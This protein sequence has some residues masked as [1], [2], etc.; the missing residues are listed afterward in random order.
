[1]KK[2][3]KRPKE[4]QLLIGRQPLLEALREAVPIEKIWIKR[5]LVREN[6]QEVFALAQQQNIPVQE[7]PI[8]KLHSLTDKNHQGIIAWISAVPYQNLEDILSQVY[9]TGEIPLFLLLDGITDVRNVGAIARSAL[10]FGAQAM[11]VP[12]KGSAALNEDALKTSA[13]ALLKIPVCR[14][15]SLRQAISYLQDNGLQIVA[16]DASG[17]VLLSQ[18]DLRIP[19][20]IVLGDEG[21]GV[22]AAHLQTADVVVQIPMREDFDSLNVSVAAGVLL[23]EAAQQRTRG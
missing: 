19:T 18:A 1:M 16:A 14:A 5:S 10:C 15:V 13:G 11:I 2:Y 17:E 22:D 9:D 12:Q 23:Y 20:A 4:K 21:S 7:V 3:T 6:L 8:E